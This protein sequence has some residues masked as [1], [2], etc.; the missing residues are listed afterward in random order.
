MLVFVPRNLPRLPSTAEVRTGRP[1]AA[2]TLAA[3]CD[4]ANHLAGYRRLRV[5][6]QFF[7]GARDTSN[8][9]QVHNTAHEGWMRWTTGL[10]ARHLWLAVSFIAQDTGATG[11]EPYIDA[12]LE[13]PDGTVL[14]SGIRFRRDDGSLPMMSEDDES[15]RAGYISVLQA[16]TPVRPSL[17]DG[18]SLTPPRPLVLP[19]PGTDVSLHFTWQYARLLSATAIEVYQETLT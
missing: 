6:S 4:R 12:V 3:M 15:M 2:A 8:H 9:F 10:V 1:V 7:E 11:G 14:D 17:A 18:G 5:V 16:Y 13:K 19:D